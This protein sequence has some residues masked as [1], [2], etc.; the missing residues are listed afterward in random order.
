MQALPPSEGSLV[1]CMYLQPSLSAGCLP[2]SSHPV[3]SLAEGVMMWKSPPSF[4]L[5]QCFT[6][7]R[8]IFIILAWFYFPC[9]V[10]FFVD[11]PFEQTRLYREN[12]LRDIVFVW[13]PCGRNLCSVT[14]PCGMCMVWWW[15][16]CLHVCI[17]GRLNPNQPSR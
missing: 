10:F 5:G 4:Y 11:A 14:D 13:R 15:L 16:L 9:Y 8:L 7:W 2:L 3:G 12:S 6:L 17:T 1:V